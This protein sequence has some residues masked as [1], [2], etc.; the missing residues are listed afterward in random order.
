MLNASLLSQENVDH[1]VPRLQREAPWVRLRAHHNYY[2]RPETGLS[3]DFMVERS[4]Q[5]VSH[6]VPVTA[7][8]ASQTDPRLPLRAGLPTVE[9][10][11]Y[12]EPAHAA[13]ELLATGVVSDVLIADP[14]ASVAHLESVAAVCGGKPTVL[15]VKVVHPLTPQEERIA[16]SSPHKAR[17]D[18]AIWSIRSST[19]R[20]MASPGEPV[21]PRNTVP[22]ERGSVTIDNA[23][24]QRYSGELQVITSDLPSDSRVNVLGYVIPE[25]MWKL[26]FIGPGDSFTLKTKVV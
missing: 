11:R 26:A 14:Y 10:H 24:Y 9:T 5:W 18:R 17:T 7:S 21:E 8:V 13:A 19:S 23:N 22:R 16:F 2:P 6:E 4:E 3:M 12:M 15:R 25:D 1:L 20:Q